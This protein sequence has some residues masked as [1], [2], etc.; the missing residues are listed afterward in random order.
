MARKRLP[1]LRARILGDGPERPAVL[2]GIAAH[3]LEGAVEAPGFVPTEVVERDLARALC[4][5]LPSRRE[6]YGLIV[7]EASAVGTPAVVVHGPDNAAT[8]LVEEG[9]NGLVAPSASPQDLAEAIVRVHAAGDALRA[10]TAAWF[11][12]NALRLSI[13]ASLD[14]VVRSYAGRRP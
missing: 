8:E 11:A 12:R 14:V 9:V 10:S 2:A 13:D 7:V 6:G 1:Q 4:M 5:V 3:G